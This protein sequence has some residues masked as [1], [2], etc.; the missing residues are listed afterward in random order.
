MKI[1]TIAI[2]G[3]A[4]VP[5]DSDLYQDIYQSARLLASSGFTIVNGGGP[6]AMLAATEGAES[7]GGNTISVTFNDKNAKGFEGNIRENN[8]DFNIKT[9]DYLDRLKGLIHNSDCF[10]VF[11][12]GTGTL[13]EFSTVWCMARLYYGNHKPI[14]LFGSF[15]HEIIDVLSANMLIRPNELKVFKIIETPKE[16]IKA[17]QYFQ[18]K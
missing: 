3:G 13:S 11:N 5:S 10:L 7:A 1:K 14:I 15:W 6:G 16:I 2:F 8:T 18:E 17:I 9:F 4:N 12:G